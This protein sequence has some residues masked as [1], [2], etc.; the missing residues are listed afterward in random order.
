MR[1]LQLVSIAI[2]MAAALVAAPV[3]AQE[4]SVTVAGA[5]AFPAGASYLGL[6]LRTL[7][8]GVGLGVAGDWASGQFQVTLTGTDILGNERNIVLNGRA[9]SGL[10]SAPGTSA[11]S[12]T[13]IVD[14]E[15]SGA[16]DTALLS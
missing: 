1:R 15:T 4:T 2:I 11:F 8:L 12:G 10:A 9:Q 7:T 13:A 3:G 5:G 14:P 16:A 6:P